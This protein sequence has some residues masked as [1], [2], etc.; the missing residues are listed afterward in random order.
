M[1]IIVSIVAAT[2]LFHYKKNSLSKMNSF[3]RNRAGALKK[4][5][6]KFDNNFSFSSSNEGETSPNTDL[7][8]P[9]F[10]HE[11]NNEFRSVSIIRFASFLLENI[12]KSPHDSF[13]SLRRP[14]ET[15][16][17]DLNSLSFSEDPLDRCES[18][19][20][21]RTLSKSED[22]LDI[23]SNNNRVSRVKYLF[24]Q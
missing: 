12:E 4:I 2:V 13:F 5:S 20:L 14:G 21:G 23:I 9:A 10:S 15:T 3:I 17:D 24:D 6:R 18:E 1:A 8:L 22:S 16:D 19:G 7:D 11:D